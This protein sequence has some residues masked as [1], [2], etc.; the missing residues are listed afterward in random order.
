[1]AINTVIVPNKPLVATSP[2]VQATGP[3]QRTWNI[4][5]TKVANDVSPHVM[6]YLNPAQPVTVRRVYLTLRKAIT[7]DLI[8]ALRYKPP[9]TSIAT[10]GSF[11]AP[12]STAVNTPIIFTSFAKS[13]L[14]DGGVVWGDITAS[15]G[16][17]D[18]NGIATVTI[19][20]IARGAGQTTAGG[21]A[22]QGTF[23][24]TANYAKG[25]TVSYNGSTYISLIANNTGTIPTTDPTKWALVAAAGA[26]GGTGATGGTGTVDP[27]ASG[28]SSWGV[29]DTPSSALAWTGS[30]SPGAGA[31]ASWGIAEIPALAFVA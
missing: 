25:D 27:G 8:V 22:W 16:S 2:S 20:Y 28:T 4:N 7:A 11:T 26:S 12:T 3:F 17:K 23:D 18:V 9:T 5:D 10:I 24:P 29:V 30:T 21:M 13:D 14:V 19:E 15:D 31:S 6:I 1:M